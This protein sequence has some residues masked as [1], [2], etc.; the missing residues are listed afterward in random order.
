MTKN[1]GKSSIAAVVFAAALLLLPLSGCSQNAAAAGNGTP[2]SSQVPS[3]KISTTVKTDTPRPAPATTSPSPTSKPPNLTTVGFTLSL[4][5]VQEY[6]EYTLPVYLRPQDTLHLT[7][8]ITTGGDH[9][10]LSFTTPKGEVVT[11]TRD[12]TMVRN[13][14]ATYP[15]E[16]L[17]NMGNVIFTAKDYDLDDGYYLF[18]LHL[19][20]GDAAVGGKIFYWIEY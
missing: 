16:K 17:F 7:W 19:R 3:P 2:L 6:T 15:D 11:L 12:G 10:S 5:T 20:R 4:A 13:Y 18:H 8:V 1:T 14:P 9:L